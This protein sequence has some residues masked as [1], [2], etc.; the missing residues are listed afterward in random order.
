MFEADG[1]LTGM[2]E[3]L[4][5]KGDLRSRKITFSRDAGLPFLKAASFGRFPSVPHCRVFGS[6]LLFLT[7]RG[8]KKEVEKSVQGKRV[9]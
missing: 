7:V 3:A 5:K 8:W 2:C 9:L 1:E 4:F 6:G